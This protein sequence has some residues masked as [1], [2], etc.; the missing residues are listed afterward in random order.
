MAD[1]A[2]QI[3]VLDDADNLDE[4]GFEQP[5]AKKAKVAQKEEPQ[6]APAADMPE[7][8]VPDDPVNRDAADAPVEEQPAAEAA[9]HVPD[10]KQ[11]GVAEDS[12][13]PGASEP[14]K[15]GYKT[16]SSGP[17]ARTYFSNLLHEA[18][19]QHPLNEVQ[20]NLESITCR[21]R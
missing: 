7:P 10:A 16:F 21:Q 18:N 8:D 17:A 12:S 14:V 19:P 1:N 5:A 2:S 6:E 9:A 3:P 4:T 11:A 15:L 13:A 20:L